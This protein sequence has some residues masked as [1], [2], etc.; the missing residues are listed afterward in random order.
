MKF[1]RAILAVVLL[2][3][4]CSCNRG[5]MGYSYTDTSEV[6]TGQVF[7]FY[8]PAYTLSVML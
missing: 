2:A 6:E 1:W 8:A 3:G 4:L 5:E 7:I